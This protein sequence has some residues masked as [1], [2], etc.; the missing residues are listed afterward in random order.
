MRFIEKF[1]FALIFFVFFPHISTY[2][3]EFL[4]MQ[5]KYSALEAKNCDLA[6]Q[7]N[8]DVSGA[9]MALTDLNSRLNDLVEQLISSYNISEDELEVS[10]KREKK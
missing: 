4:G 10:Y 6:V 5:S 7:R 9:T 8:N 3:Q 2:R 1:K